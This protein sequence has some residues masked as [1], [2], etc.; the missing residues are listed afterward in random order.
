MRASI[1]GAACRIDRQFAGGIEPVIREVVRSTLD[2]AAISLA[3]IEMVVTVASDTLDG[4]MVPIR[5]ELAGALGK[6][7]LNVSSAAGHAV[8]AAAAAIE[9]GDADTVLIV[10]WG[11]ASKLAI[12]D[13]RANQFDPFYM[14]PLGATPKVMAALQKQILVASGA[15]SE[16]NIEAFRARM[17][18]RVWE[19]G[20]GDASQ[21]N[22]FC[23]GVA[24]LVMRRASEGQGGIV[25]SD[26]ATASRSH[27]PLDGSF[28]PAAWVREAISGF[29]GARAKESAARGF[30]EV[31]GSSICAELRGI[32]A[33]VESGL[34]DCDGSSANSMGGGAAAWFGPA[35]G[36]RALAMLCGD[37]EARDRDA[38]L[39]V[40]LAGPLGQHVTSIFIERRS[41]A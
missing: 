5:A 33:S 29:S 24:A 23:D 6:N 4:M 27:N 35:T 11:A 18:D 40:D 37:G 14:R 25:I 15:L 16:N 10:G 7:Y 13:G 26:H 22:G 31:S 19:G 21:A 8:C 32:V 20:K 9:A 39:F 17:T 30:I 28:D 36:L 3:D 2:A 12:A 34:V 38:G 41:E 1:A